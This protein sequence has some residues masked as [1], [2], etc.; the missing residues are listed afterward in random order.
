MYDMSGNT[1]RVVLLPRVAHAYAVSSCGRFLH[2]T[3]NYGCVEDG[4]D[5][6]E[7]TSGHVAYMGEWSDRV[8]HMF[9][10]DFKKVIFILMTIRA[11]LETTSYEY[12]DNRALS[13]PRLPIEVWLLIFG[14]YQAATR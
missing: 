3:S 8:H 13:L 5:V 11:M 10:R 1:R 9:R 7:F 4:D 6:L 14:W 2:G 12:R